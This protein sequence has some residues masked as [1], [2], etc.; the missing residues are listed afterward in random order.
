MEE[1]EGDVEEDMTPPPP[2]AVASPDA[3]ASLDAAAS[4][5][6]EAAAAATFSV[7]TDS[8]LLLFLVAAAWEGASPGV[9]IQFV[10]LDLGVLP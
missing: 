2:D 9:W 5:F 1:D 6:S 3:A 8:S 4:T 7:G 10:N